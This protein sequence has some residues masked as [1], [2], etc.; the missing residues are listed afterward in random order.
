[1]SRGERAPRRG[2][3]LVLAS[4]PGGGKT[5]VSRALLETEPELSLSVSAT[6]RAPRPG[7]REGVHYFFRTP[8]AIRRHGSRPA[9]SWNMPSFLGR[10]LRHAARPGGGGAGGRAGRAVRHRMAGPP[11]VARG[12]PGDVVGIFLLPPSLAELE[13][14]LRG[15]G[16]DPEDEIARRMAAARDRDARIGTS[17]TMCW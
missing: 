9:N 6:T 5:S 13:R 15:R 1:M 14:R 10:V 16:Q 12:V 3:C 7:E 17:S 8:G 11:A 4:A 2:I